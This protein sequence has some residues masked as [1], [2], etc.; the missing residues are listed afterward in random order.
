[1]QVKRIATDSTEAV[2]ER[3][4]NLKS[5][6]SKLASKDADFRQLCH[7]YEDLSGALEGKADKEAGYSDELATLQALEEEILERIF[8]QEK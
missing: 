8:R 3:F 6:L 2:S 7:D 1:M 4:P 5:E